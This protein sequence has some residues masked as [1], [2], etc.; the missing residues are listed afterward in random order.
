MA[1]PFIRP[2][3]QR[4]GSFYTFTSASRDLV[5]SFNEDEIKFQFS[6]FALINIPNIKKPTNDQNFIQLDAIDG[7][8]NGGINTISGVDINNGLATHFQNYALNFEELL[9]K[10]GEQSDRVK[11]SPAERV[12]WKW[13]KEIGGIRFRD[14]NQTTES[15]VENRYTEENTTDSGDRQYQRVVEYVGDIK[16]VNNV[17]NPENAFTQ[18]NIYVATKDGNTP[19]VL[20]KTQNDQYYSEGGIYQGSGEF[21]EGR[22][23]F[24]NH[25]AGL[26]TSAYYDYDALNNFTNSTN[27]KWWGTTN[28]PNSYYTEPDF[29]DSSS[30]RRILG[31]ADYASADNFDGVNYLRSNLD[32]ICLDFDPRSY[33]A[34]QS[35]ESI[36]SIQQFNSTFGATDFNFNAVLVYYDV[37]DTSNPSI[38]STNLYGILFLDNVQSSL[39][40]GGFIQ[41]YPKYKADPVTKL[42]GNSFSLNINIKFDSSIGNP[43]VDTAVND[44]SAYSM[45]LFS[46][47]AIEY[48]RGAQLL[49]KAVEKYSD[50]E[51]KYFDLENRYL[52]TTAIRLLESR[53]NQLENNFANSNLLVSDMQQIL[54]LIDVV[55]N[56]IQSI[57]DGKLD[58]SLQY[59]TDVINGGRGIS[60]DKSVPNKVIFNNN[61][62]EWNNVSKVSFNYGFNNNNEV[63][64][65]D[66]NNVFIEEQN[67]VV[68]DDNVQ[69][70]LDDTNQFLTGQSVKIKL[71]SS[72]DPKIYNLSILTDKTGEKSGNSY[73]KVIRAIT[74]DIINTITGNIV[75]EIYCIDGPNYEF[76]TQIYGT[77]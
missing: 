75:I 31:D 8:I 45:S 68:F 13:M 57:I 35:N 39:S 16:L 48:Q 55:N 27:A 7:A 42:N 74:P 6:K 30:E 9:I 10:Q 29:T 11:K 34:I 26:S 12:F 60:V 64:I 41:R 18:L 32:G 4:G 61:I 33:R 76:E 17:L 58:V 47:S 20:F 44:Y 59:N 14:A 51:Q 50:L 46:E 67:S 54:D 69:I 3:N 72:I 56:K 62:Q 2:I 71:P 36:S 52:N 38:R 37:F 1:A 5:N 49:Q 77:L 70:K 23:E 19:T 43:T 28:I 73:S 65:S 53:I 25:P 40:E 63:V 22:D 21:I 24:D 15:T 66:Y